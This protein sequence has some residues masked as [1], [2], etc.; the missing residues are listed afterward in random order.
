[1]LNPKPFWKSKTLWW[2]LASFVVATAQPIGVAIEKK[3]FKP[4]ELGGLVAFLFTTGMSVYA[5]STADR[6]L[7]VKGEPP[8]SE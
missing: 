1:M 3:Q 6:P 8:M 5:R 2:I 4:S 7:T